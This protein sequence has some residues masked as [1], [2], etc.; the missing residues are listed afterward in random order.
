MDIIE[1]GIYSTQSSLLGYPDSSKGRVSNYYPG[2]TNLSRD[3]VRMVQEVLY[4]LKQE[5]ENTRLRKLNSI[6]G[7][8][9]YEL[10][11][12]SATKKI[13]GNRKGQEVHS[14]DGKRFEIFFTTGDHSRELHAVNKCLQ[15]AKKYASTERQAQMIEKYLECFETGDIKA[16]KDAQHLWVQDGSPTVETLHGFIEYYRDPHQVRAEWRGA[17]LIENKQESQLYASLV[18]NARS[19]IQLLPWNVHSTAFE[20]DD[21]KAPVF[22]VM[23]GL[24]HYPYLFSEVNQTSAMTFVSSSIPAGTNGPNVCSPFPQVQSV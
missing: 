14:K 3:E 21:F 9:R 10:L 4:V 5:T 2:T 18:Q 8:D 17:V 12:A 15:E 1:E 16:H 7:I 23:D 13:S 6:D 20:A 22:R 24:S 19:C 11:I